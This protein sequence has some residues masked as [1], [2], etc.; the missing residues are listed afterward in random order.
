M[1]SG[2]KAAVKMQ[3]IAVLA[4]IVIGV[5]AIAIWQA[6]NLLEP[7]DSPSPS[8]SASPAVTLPEMTLTV[9]GATGEQ[10]VLDENDIAELETYT[11]PSG[12]KSSGG[13]IQAVGTYTGVPVPVLC[14][15]VGGMTSE[16][17]LTV[18]A[19]DGYSMVYTYEQVQGE[20]FTTYYATNGSEAEATQPMVMTAN[21]LFNDEPFDEERGPIR[22]GVV[23][24]EGLLTEGHFWTK[25]TVELKITANI[26][27]WVVTVF[28]EDSEPLNMDRQAWTAE[29]N[30]FPL[31]YTDDNGNIWTGTAL[32]RWVS[33]YNYNGGI[34]NAT[35][36]EGYS[37]K[38]I[39]GD[40]YFATID[41]SQ[42]KMNDNIII[43]GELNGEPLP[44]P[45]WPLRL[46]GPDVTQSDRVG[47]IIEI[48]VVLDN[49]TAST[50]APSMTAS[51]SASPSATP[52]PTPT[53]S[54]SPSQDYTL[55][56][57]GTTAVDML[58]ATFE[59]QV[60]LGS[61][62]YTNAD[63]SVLAGAPLYAIVDWA[64][65]SGVVESSTL[66]DGYVVKVIASDGY[67]KAFNDTFV[68]GNTNILVAN[69]ADGAP[70]TGDYW[71]LTLTGSD[72]S[73]K[74]NIKGVA[75]IQILPF[76]RTI[77]LTV[78]GSNGTEVTLYPADIVALESYNA[79]GGTMGRQGKIN[80]IGTY[81]G[82]PILTLCDLVG[83]VTESNT[84]KVI[85]SDDYVTEYTYAEVNGE[86]DVYTQEGEA[87]TATEDLTMIVA[88]N[89]NGTS[90][91]SDLGPLRTAILGPEDLLT[92]G[93][94]WAKMAVRVEV[95]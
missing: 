8:P 70:L 72:L 47:N 61:A 63:G 60:S 81:I 33:W 94:M 57:S 58:R 88:Y 4:I 46:V 69:T 35:L 87:T 25:M 34:S 27:D 19:A 6:P 68:E 38:L 11:G 82:V 43:A 22:I 84:V 67:A 74:E 40:G 32:W 56:V 16:Q 80:Y 30:H 83:G 29:I 78:V 86:V 54:A 52:T 51:P 39:A 45:Y 13:M 5:S 20:G 71:P 79:N 59:A 3:V 31:D 66:D 9:I 64:Q 12:Y 50:P 48:E 92:P 23:G 53:P 26:A 85:S 77:T 95:I 73:R 36:D 62:T 17:T 14:D 10:V 24:P 91:P 49:P 42:V 28:E 55:V 7:S 65:T 44:D 1:N 18:T 90:I 93:F 2:K 15:L 37:V 41:D 76:D 21:Y 89:C 75:Q